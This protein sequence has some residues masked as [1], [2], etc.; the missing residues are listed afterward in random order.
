MN[1]DEDW[2]W[3][4]DEQSAYDLIMDVIEHKRIS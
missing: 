1:E 3:E 4:A 2:I